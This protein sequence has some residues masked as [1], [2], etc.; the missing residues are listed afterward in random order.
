MFLLCRTDSCSA[1]FR[2]T[3]FGK[4]FARRSAD[5]AVANCF[6]PMGFRFPPNWERF[7]IKDHYIFFDITFWD[8][9][10][11]ANP[12]TPILYWIRLALCH[13]WFGGVA[14]IV[15]TSESYKISMAVLYHCWWNMESWFPSTN[16]N[17]FVFNCWVL[18]LW[19]G[20]SD[21]LLQE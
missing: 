14:C 17:S 5:N 1:P 21:I 12:G 18:R 10:V 13:R 4:T 7:Q 2:W 3:R 20:Y 15:W 19:W 11:L 6:R 16:T 8:L 9:F